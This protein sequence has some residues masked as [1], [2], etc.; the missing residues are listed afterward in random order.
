[1]ILPLLIMDMPL[2]LDWNEIHSYNP[3]W[4]PHAKFHRTQTM[5]MG[6]HQVQKEQSLLPDNMRAQRRRRRAL[7]LS[8]IPV[9]ALIERKLIDPAD[10]RSGGCR[11]SC[12][13]LIIRGGG[14]SASRSSD[15]DL[16]SAC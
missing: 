4:S 1:V 16:Q 8:S 9:P 13:A 6:V 5:S 10:L 12:L 15:V 7:M 11:L 3:R 2:L 14:G